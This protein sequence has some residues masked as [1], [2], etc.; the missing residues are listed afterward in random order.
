[1]VLFSRRCHICSSGKKIRFVIVNVHKK[2]V[3]TGFYLTFY[4]KIEIYWRLGR[5]IFLNSQSQ[6]IFVCFVD[7]CTA[8]TLWISRYL[9][10][11]IYFWFSKSFIIFSDSYITRK[12]KNSLKKR[13]KKKTRTYIRFKDFVFLETWKCQLKILSTS[14]CKLKIF[15]QTFFKWLSKFSDIFFGIFGNF[16]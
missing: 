6:R 15:L 3:V 14:K 2:Q 16:F 12:S 10:T 5:H 4:D 9:K 1:M 11:G 13:I 8:L 7:I